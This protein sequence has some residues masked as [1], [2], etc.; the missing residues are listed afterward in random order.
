MSITVRKAGN[1]DIAILAEFL[2]ELFSIESDFQVDEVRQREG[3]RLLLENETA[4]I[5]LVAEYEGRVC[6]MLSGQ[7]VV[8]T[9]AGAYSIL[10]E[11][12][13]VASEFRRNGVATKLLAVLE[14][15]GREK[16]ARRM[17][18][19]ADQNNDAALALYRK[20]NFTCGQMTAL[21]RSF[22]G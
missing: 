13:Y 7:L 20:N 12:M 17:Q 22:A 21:Y 11:D 5:V 8:S 14:K 3:L 10:V 18:L 15:W 1:N 4:A 16:G 6:G 2:S 9:A 19:V